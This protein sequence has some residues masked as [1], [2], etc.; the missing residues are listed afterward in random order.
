M[1]GTLWL[2]PYASGTIEFF[3]RDRQAGE[4]HKAITRLTARKQSID[5]WES[6]HFI[7]TFKW[8]DWARAASDAT[9]DLCVDVTCDDGIMHHGRVSGL[10]PVA[11][12]LVST[13]SRVQVDGGV[14]YFSPYLTF[15]AHNISVRVGSLNDLA[16]RA[17]KHAV[18]RS[19]LKLK[20]ALRTDGQ[21]WLIGELPHKAQ[22]NGL[23]FLT[24]LGAHQ[25][26]IDA[27]FVLDANSPDMSLARAAG[28]VIERGS[29]EH[30]EASFAADILATTHH[31]EYI[32]PLHANDLNRHIHARRVFLQH[33]ILGTKWIANLYGRGVQGFNPSLFV[34]SSERERAIITGDLGF[35]G[36]QVK[37]TGLTRFDRLLTARAPKREILVA[38]TWRDWLQAPQQLEDS[39]FLAEWLGL[40]EDARFLSS[41]ADARFDVTMLLHPNFRHFAPHFATLGVRTVEPETV[42]VQ[43]LVMR[44]AALV[45]DYSSLG[46]DMALLHR[47][48]VYFQFDRDRFLGK[49]GSHL[50]LDVDL[51][52]TVTRD[53]TAA[54]TAFKS[55]ID[56][57]FQVSAG[58]VERA[59]SYFP[60][61]DLESSRRTYEAILALHDG[62]RPR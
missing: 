19:R 22:D 2:P 40:L 7:A 31:P 4:R 8:V 36:E 30:V 51:P 43:D 54:A 61:H 50:D 15:K 42:C 37:V 6:R 24:Y 20:P 34:A 3:A 5:S 13:T 11:R 59:D 14:K 62:K 27:R 21:L 60:P 10:S 45:T 18:R 25:P 39:E 28:R 23:A 58:D 49:E 57:D 33:G 47:P 41:A 38:P 12:R 26:Q 56:S 46:F 1:S 35:P 32:L 17:L 29:V 44:S 9:L 16:A 55:V 53:R 52:G 48:V